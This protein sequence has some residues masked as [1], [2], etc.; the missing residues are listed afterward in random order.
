MGRGVGRARSPPST[1]DPLILACTTARRSLHSTGLQLSGH[2]G[3]NAATGIDPGSCSSVPAIAR[4]SLSTDV[5]SMSL[6]S[7]NRALAAVEFKYTS[8]LAAKWRRSE[9]LRANAPPRADQNAVRIKV[10]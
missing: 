4:L 9:S 5:P 6:I 1:P 10:S 2:S 7:A 3:G 8:A